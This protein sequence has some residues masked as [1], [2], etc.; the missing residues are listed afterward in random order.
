MV[1]KYYPHDTENTIRTPNGIHLG[2]R[3]YT[4]KGEVLIHVKDG[5]REDY[6]TIKKL[7]ECASGK[8]VRKLELE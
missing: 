1:K 5:K 2:D 8:R 6:L 7:I 4:D 3:V